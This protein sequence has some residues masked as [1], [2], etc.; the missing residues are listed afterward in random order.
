M[1][2]QRT[3]S[4]GKADGGSYDSSYRSSSSGRSGAQSKPTAQDYVNQLNAGQKT[5]QD[6]TDNALRQEQERQAEQRLERQQAESEQQQSSQGQANTTASSQDQNPAPISYPADSQAVQQYSPPPSRA[7]ADYAPPPAV[8]EPYQPPQLAGYNSGDSP[9]ILN[10][11]QANPSGSIFSEVANSLQSS[12]DSEPSPG[13]PLALDDRVFGVESDDHQS[14]L[15]AAR[16]FRDSAKE[17]LDSVRESLRGAIRD[18][19]PIVRETFSILSDKIL[20]QAKNG[21]SGDVKAASISGIQDTAKGTLLNAA[22]AMTMKFFDALPPNL[23]DRFRGGYNA[24]AR[25]G[26]NLLSFPGADQNVERS[27]NEQSKIDGFS[28]SVFGP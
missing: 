12:S 27:L 21:E 1:P 24:L 2:A 25:P 4:A 15:Q 13:E 7:T 17:S 26:V 8:V 11:K 19:T 9:S 6:A 18:V 5:I 20:D 22:D 28:Q 10:G 14:L 16:D 3:G 23:R